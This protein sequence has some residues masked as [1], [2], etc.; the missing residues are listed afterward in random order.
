MSAI[1]FTST[2]ATTIRYHNIFLVLA[3]CTTQSSVVASINISSG[4]VNLT[5]TFGALL[6]QY[7]VDIQKY[8]VH[9]DKVK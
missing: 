9:M 5:I 3:F 8:H 6:E 7:V 1:D 4:H 2:S